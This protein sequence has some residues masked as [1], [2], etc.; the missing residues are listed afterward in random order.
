MII[1]TGC[2]LLVQQL[3][4]WHYEYT[5]EGKNGQLFDLFHRMLPDL[6]RQ[7]WIIQLI[8]FG[9]GLFTI[10]QP[11]ALGILRETFWKLLVVMI[12]RAMTTLATILP[13]HERC[14]PRTTMQTLWNGGCYD[15]IFSG[16]TALVTMLTLVLVGDKNI[17]WGAFWG[18]NIVNAAAILLT[19]AHYT[20]DVVL[21][22]VISYLVYDGD[23][24][25]FTNFFKGVGT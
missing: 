2:N 10:L 18:I 22:F 3:G 5:E 7:E 24:T 23:Y 14:V 11:N 8:P 12:I 16:H 6:H 15:K 25:I 1:I 9:L 19:R 13:K 21:A 4:D 17:S 20:V